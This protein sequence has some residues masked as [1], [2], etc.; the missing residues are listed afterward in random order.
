MALSVYDLY[1]LQDW[2]GNG[3]T[4]QGSDVIIDDTVYE[5]REEAAEALEARKTLIA[6]LP[7]ASSAGDHIT[8]MT[9]DDFLSR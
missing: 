6:N 2:S 4:G 7:F 8:I 1:V 9:L 5:S 3:F